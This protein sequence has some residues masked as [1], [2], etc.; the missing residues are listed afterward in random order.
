MDRDIVSRNVETLQIHQLLI[1]LQVKVH[2][3]VGIVTK[4]V[5][6]ASTVVNLEMTGKPTG[7]REANIEIGRRTVMLSKVS[8]SL[9]PIETACAGLFKT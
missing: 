5:G 1:F 8:P 6:V 2:A 9:L 3:Y 7:S 4:A